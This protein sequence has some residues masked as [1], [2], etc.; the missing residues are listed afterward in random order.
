TTSSST[1]SPVSKWSSSGNLM[2]GY[3]ATPEYTILDGPTVY[4]APVVGCVGGKSDCCPFSVPASTQA[5]GASGGF[6]IAVDPAQATLDRCP[7]DYQSVG[8]GC[9]P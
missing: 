3:C 5:V 4:W 1:H 2:Q 6:P 9:C 7:D 8:D